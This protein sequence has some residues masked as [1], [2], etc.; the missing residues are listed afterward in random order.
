MKTNDKNNDIVADI[1]KSFS[2]D[3]YDDKMD[4][5]HKDSSGT[6]KDDH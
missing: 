3:D 2:W 1:I 4:R 6:Q 5:V